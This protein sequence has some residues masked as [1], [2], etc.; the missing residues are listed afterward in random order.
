MPVLSVAFTSLS[1]LLCTA[2]YLIFV[3]HIM[4]G[5]IRLVMKLRGKY[6]RGFWS[7]LNI[8]IISCSWTNMAIY[9]WRYLESVDIGELFAKHNGLVSVNLQTIVYVNDAFTCLLAFC[10][11]F[12]TI[13]LVRLGRFN[14]RLMFFL[15]TLHH[16][17]RELISFACMFSILFLAFIALFHLLFL[18]KLA[19]CATMFQTAR[20]LFEMT[21]MKFDAYQLT[22]AASL[23]G[24]VAFALF[25]F[26]VVF[27]CMS[28][29]LTIIN[30]SFR[31][32]RDNADADADD[33]QHILA[34]VLDKLQLWLGRERVPLRIECIVLFLP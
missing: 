15:R 8:G 1:Q 27:V 7:W 30:E 13:R 25:I 20:M 17:A 29:F 32:V 18:S 24:P 19:T 26:V 10:C 28:M 16:A 9:I 11:F 34:F 3:V 22:Q 33:D 23:L 6:F 2:V 31:H 21:L 14:H 4:I 12:G 5:E